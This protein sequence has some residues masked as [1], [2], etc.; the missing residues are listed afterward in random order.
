MY[1]Y[2]REKIHVNHLGVR[3]LSGY[4][5]VWEKERVDGWGG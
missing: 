3:G 1:G 5:V 2:Y 4:Q